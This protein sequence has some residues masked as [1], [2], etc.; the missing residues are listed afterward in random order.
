MG[1]L[2]I[3]DSSVSRASILAEREHAYLNRS[4]EQKFHALLQLNRVSVQMNGGK[5]L[6]TPQGLG[7]VIS[8]SGK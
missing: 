4:S 7:L 2:K 1:S 8:R 3:Y 6:K 5:P